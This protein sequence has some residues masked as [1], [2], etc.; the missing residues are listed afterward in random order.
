MELTSACGHHRPSRPAASMLADAMAHRHM[1]RHMCHPR[2]DLVGTAA[3]ETDEF[4]RRVRNPIRV[5]G[6]MRA[7]TSST[8]ERPG[9]DGAA[10]H[11]ES[12]R[13]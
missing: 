3:A 5:R 6:P 13:I 12:K 2:C 1:C 4:G 9:L 10:A 11:K 7:R 8:E